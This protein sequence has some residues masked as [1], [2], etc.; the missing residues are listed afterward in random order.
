MSK[1]RMRR[2]KEEGRINQKNPEEKNPRTTNS[3]AGKT[4]KRRRRLAGETNSNVEPFLIR[5]R[6][7]KRVQGGGLGGRRLQKKKPLCSV[8]W[9]NV[10]KDEAEKHV[11]ISDIEQSPRGRC[12]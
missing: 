5:H 9:K 3:L 2:L 4:T 12:R 11:E 1:E 8:Q 7:D 10:W 6:R